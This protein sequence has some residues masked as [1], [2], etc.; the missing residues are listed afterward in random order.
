MQS[1][2]DFSEGGPVSELAIVDTFTRLIFGEQDYNPREM[3]IIQAFRMADPNVFLDSHQGMGEY[4]RGLGVREMIQL[5]SRMQKQLLSGVQL[6]ADNAAHAALASAG[7]H[8][9]NR[10]AH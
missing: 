4:L 6:M 2:Y 3:Q 9:M 1:A 7:H 8:V 10:R 5:V